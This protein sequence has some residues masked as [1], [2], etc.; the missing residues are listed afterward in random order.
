MANGEYV[1]GKV[2]WRIVEIVML[3]LLGINISLTGWAL[4]KIVSISERISV[5]E[6]RQELTKEKIDDL[7]K[8]PNKLRDVK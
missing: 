3:I 4:N 2:S 7:Y 8:N 5:V 1:N 6:T